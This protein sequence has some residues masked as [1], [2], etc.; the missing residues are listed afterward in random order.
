MEPH[1]NKYDGEPQQQALTEADLVPEAKRHMSEQ[2]YNFFMR[3]LRSKTQEAQNLLKKDG[4]FL[5]SHAAVFKPVQDT[6][7]ILAFAATIPGGHRFKIVCQRTL[8]CH[9][10]DTTLLLLDQVEKQ[11]DNIN[12]CFKGECSLLHSAAA[13]GYL[14]VVEKIV[15]VLVSGGQRNFDSL[16]YNKR[17]PLC[18]AIEYGRKDVAEFLM[19]YTNDINPALGDGTTAMH[20][21]AEQG[22]ITT[23]DLLRKHIQD[24]QKEGASIGNNWLLQTD[25]AYRMGRINALMSDLKVSHPAIARS[26]LKQV[27]EELGMAAREFN[28]LA[29]AIRHEG[30]EGVCNAVEGC[31]LALTQSL[32]ELHVVQEPLVFQEN[33]QRRRR[34]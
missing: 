14:L 8:D 13:Q 22:S 7:D 16:K 5:L 30:F 28:S 3:A 2:S 26:C 4:D 25:C 17:T 12:P 23:L 19:Q 29:T 27:S 11:Q 6:K 33:K 15:Q 24:L 18:L 20:R 21:A 34:R 9:R 32:S 31:I 10:V 1:E